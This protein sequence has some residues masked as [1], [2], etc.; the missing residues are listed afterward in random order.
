MIEMMKHLIP[1]CPVQFGLG[2]PEM[3][4]FELI[5]SVACR[6]LSLGKS[7]GRA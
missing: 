3:T 6:A 1:L 2:F 4:V 7:V 5:L